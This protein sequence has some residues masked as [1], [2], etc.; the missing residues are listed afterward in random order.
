[1][2]RDP[3][4]RLGYNNLSEIKNH[5]FFKSIDFNKLENLGYM[6]PITDFTFLKKNVENKDV[7][8]V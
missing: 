4:K 7:K 5:P 3:T 2:E 8:L 6:P 1:L